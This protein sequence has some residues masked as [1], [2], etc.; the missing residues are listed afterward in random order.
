MSLYGCEMLFSTAFHPQT[1]GMAEVTNRI[2][3]QLLLCS[4]EEE[5]REEKLPNLEM[6]YNRR[7]QL[8]TKESPNYVMLGRQLKFPVDL[9][10]SRAA[11]PAAMETAS[12][13]QAVWERV[14]Q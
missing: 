8:R 14:R 6:V 12:E 5:D 7:P 13:M 9:D 2:M 1:D 4:A 11:V 10:F 3:K